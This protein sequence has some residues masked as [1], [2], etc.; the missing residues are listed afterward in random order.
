MKLSRGELDCSFDGRVGDQ[1]CEAYTRGNRWFV[2]SRTSMRSSKCASAAVGGPR[3]W[4]AT[5]H[6]AQGELHGGA[7]VSSQQQIEFGMR[8]VSYEISLFDAA[9]HLPPGR[10]VT[11]QDA[12]FRIAA[13]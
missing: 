5:L 10:G 2:W 4:R 9:G 7:K 1:A 8:E 13:D 3:L 11:E 6:Q 12:R